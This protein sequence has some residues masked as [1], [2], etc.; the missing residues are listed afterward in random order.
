MPKLAINGGKPVR[1]K[2]F[3]AYKVIGKEEKKAVCRVLDSGVLSKYLGCWDPDFYG[4]PEVKKFEEEWAEHFNIRHAI[5]VNSCTSGLQCAV[6]AIGISP[7]D[8]VIV[9]PFT[10]AASVT[11]PIIYGGVPVFADIEEEYFCLN[12]KS[13]EE[14]ITER[15]KA[16]IVVDVLGQPYDADAINSLA[17]KYNLFV[18]EDC[19]QAPEAKYKGKFAGTL[20]DLGVY[21]L[22]YHKHIHT[23]EGGV[24]V[25]DND[26]LAER[27]RM[28]RNH[29]DAVM[30][31]RNDISN[32]VNM[33]GFNMRLTE[34]QAAIGRVQLQKLER[35]VEERLTNCRYLKEKLSQIPGIHIPPIREGATHSYYV[36]ALL[37]KKNETGIERDKFIEAVSAELPATELRESEGT[38]L[39][40]GGIKPLYMMPIF[41]K[42]IAIGDQGFPFSPKYYSG[43]VNYEKGICPVAERL[44]EEEMVFHEFMRP[45]IAKGDLDDVVR[46][47]EKVYENRNELL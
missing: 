23:G 11:C 27:I 28:I 34:L 17:K 12:P 3:P 39:S 44:N 24:V 4:G 25:T 42:R 26:E 5:A 6:G 43:I 21:S 20:G 33:V 36:Q 31:G 30:A 35:L 32:L 37:Y 46:A 40:Y 2:L 29:A 19:A 10:M 16:I 15:T 38:L 9:T 41:Q 47:F 22:N 8:E 1:T 7:G 18:I 14:R 13:V 45:P